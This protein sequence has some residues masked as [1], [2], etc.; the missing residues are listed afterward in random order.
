MYARSFVARIKR[1]QGEWGSEEMAE[2]G[3]GEEVLKVSGR[4]AR[5]EKEK[6][7]FRGRAAEEILARLKRGFRRAARRNRDGKFHGEFELS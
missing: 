6:I 1:F 2:G 5:G 3:E 4:R 7:E